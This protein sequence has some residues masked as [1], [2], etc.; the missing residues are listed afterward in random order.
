MLFAGN[1]RFNIKARNDILLGPTL[2]TF[3]LPQGLNNRFW[4]KTYFS[5]ETGSSGTTVSSF[6]GGITHRYEAIL[7]GSVSPIPILQS[8]M[9]RQNVYAGTASSGHSSYYQPWIRL[10]EQDVSFFNKVAS[11]NAPTLLST[12]FAGSINVVGSGSF[13]PSST[14]TIELLA[15]DGITGLNSTGRSVI[16][17]A[18]VTAWTYSALNVSDA[19]PASLPGITTP[20][21]YQ[22]FTGRDLGSAQLSNINALSD[23]NSIFQETGSIT[24]TARSIESQRLLHA[25]TLL[26]KGDMSPVRLYAGG[27]DLTGI[28][29]FSPKFA[30]IFS[31]RDLTDVAFYLQNTDV[32]DIS[33]VSAG[34]DIIPFNENS[35]VRSIAT[36]TT[37]RNVLQSVVQTTVA[38][39]TTTALAGDIQISGP[40][41]LEVLAGRNLDLGTGAN[42]TAGT[43]VGI[44][45]VANARNPFL[46]STG[47]NLI[48]LTG[49]GGAQG[50]GPALG[51]S[52]SSLEFEGFIQLFSNAI[53]AYPALY[54]SD[55]EG[56]ANFA[57]LSEEQKAVVALEYF[58]ELLREAG[59]SA[60]A[61]GT[62]D[63][64]YEAID[65]LLQSAAPFGELLTRSRDIRTVSGGSITLAALGGGLTLASDIIGNP[66][67]PPGI[68]TEFGGR[69]DI[70]TKGN[71]DIGQARIFTLRGGDL[72]IWSSEGDIAAGNAPK[73]VVTAPPTR[74]VID[75]NSAALQT[76][77]GGLATGGGIGVLAS[78]EGVEP[79]NI[80][81][82]APKG[83]VDAGD[84]GIRATGNIT[85]AAVAVLNAENISAAG[86]SVGVPTAPTVAAPNIAGLTSGNSATA[87]TSSAA[88]SVANQ[89]NQ[90]PQ[91]TIETPSIISVEVL[92]YGGGD[93]DEG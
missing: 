46:P 4:Y 10:A 27:G 88:D 34:R 44:T 26:H 83:V 22:A 70:F 61:G 91:E 59:V 37:L 30:R 29:L 17:G 9:H 12:A 31:D 19:D 16:N 63:R 66:Q 20:I 75:S 87:A 41:L 32:A 57:S 43:G 11:V 56:G 13:F 58:Y 93:S 71:V 42:F 80:S 69:V 47:A 36:D 33:V 92:G 62:Y 35:A 77:L 65:S 73:T 67:T 64:G 1:S 8:W 39:T 81:L 49:V 53:K 5:T 68:V 85:I 60:A 38:G 28:T 84:A 89:A 51:L 18:N 79:G 23:V 50:G 76:D 82:I 72:T 24:G 45:S 54:L 48:A 14:G 25:S 55:L 40:G 2:D 7:P 15:S 21:A 90:Q 86:T 6:G 3:L 78:V 52:Q 74:V